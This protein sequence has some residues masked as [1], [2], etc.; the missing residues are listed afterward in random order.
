MAMVRKFTV[1][2][3]AFANIE[4]SLPK[5][6]L[7]GALEGVSVASG[8]IKDFLSNPMH[9]LKPEGSRTWMTTP[10]V[11]VSA[12]D[13]PTVA[14][15]LVERRICEVIPLSQVLHVQG[16]PILGGLFGVPKAEEINGV[17]VLRLIMDLRPVNQLFEAV[18]GDL[19]TLPMWSQLFPL[20]IFP[21]DKI[22]VSSEDI[23]AMFYIIGLSEA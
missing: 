21:E 17:P 7:A 8:G 23:N 16:R 14:A 18:V 1:H 20:E 4:H 9:Y 5:R 15:G 22:L 11:M 19:H 3:F 12:D 6:E 2:S 13:W 10:R